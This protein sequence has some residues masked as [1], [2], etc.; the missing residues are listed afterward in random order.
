MSVSI[1]RGTR[2]A[3]LTG[4]VVIGLSLAACSSGGAA[5]AA[6]EGSD[7]PRGTLTIVTPYGAGGSTDVAARALIDTLEKELGRTVIVEN[8][9]GASGI[10][11]TS[12]VATAKA[13]GSKILFAV[14]NVLTQSVIRE[15]PY[16]F[17]S[18][19][20]VRGFFSMAYLA[21][22][23]ADSPHQTWADLAKAPKVNA[24]SS[25]WANE[26]HVDTAMV[27]EQVGTDV[28]IVPFDGN[29]PATQALLGGN[30]DV[31]IGDTQAIMPHVDAGKVRVLAALTP[32]GE[33][34]SYLPDVPTLEEEGI[35]TSEMLLPDWGFA[36]PQGTPDAVVERWSDA[37][38][39]ASETD[40]YREFVTKNYF[41][42]PSEEVAAN[43]YAKGKEDSAGY[44]DVLKKFNIEI[45]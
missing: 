18:F 29:A 7:M 41:I 25:G 21:A 24:A 43:W 39:K 27:F 12:D 37:I 1:R 6:G 17:D 23:P 44:P 11:G 16:S 19:R 13:D 30:V 20:Q 35:D 33:R 15:T 32:D 3:T 36:A 26:Q 45:K 40:A 9:P 38:K 14:D 42:M 34:L 8:K 10:T 22:V 5:P 2:L 28:T 31:L 4:A